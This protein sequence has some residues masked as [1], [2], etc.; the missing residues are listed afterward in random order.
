MAGD[1]VKVVSENGILGFS[2]I[3]VY[4]YLEYS[5]IKDVQSGIEVTDSG[6]ITVT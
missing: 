2:I 5:V 6:D 1:Y 3:E 4:Q